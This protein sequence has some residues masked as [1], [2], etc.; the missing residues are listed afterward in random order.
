M[1][2]LF[3]KILASFSVLALTLTVIPTA[4][5]GAQAASGYYIEVDITNRVVTIYENGNRTEAGKVAQMICSTGKSGTPTPMGTFTLPGKTYSSERT[6]WYYFSQYSCWAKWAMTPRSSMRIKRL[7]LPRL[8]R[9]PSRTRGLPAWTTRKQ[10]ALRSFLWD[11]G[12]HTLQ[13]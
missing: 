9:L 1:K 12:L 10:P 3:L 8:P 13:R 5:P 7:L 4:L 11:T 2:A 6:E